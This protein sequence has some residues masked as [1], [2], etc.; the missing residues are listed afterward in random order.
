MINVGGGDV[1]QGLM[2]APVIVRF[3]EA[4]QGPFKF[5]GAEVFLELHDV[6][7][8]PVTNLY[9]Y[10]EAFSSLPPGI[11]DHVTRMTVLGLRGNRLQTLPDDLFERLTA[12]QTLFFDGN[13]GTDSFVPTAVAGD[14][15][16]VAPGAAVTLDATASGG[17]WGTN[18][19][20]AWTLASSLQRV[21]LFRRR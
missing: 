18:V 20:Y 4:R 12:L 16:A 11:F 2:I 14:D 7:H 1:I 3:D 10:D 17:A 13:P 19:T 8:R 6:L 21:D 9:V 15:Q 5:P